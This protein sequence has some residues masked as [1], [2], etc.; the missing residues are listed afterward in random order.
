MLACAGIVGVIVYAIYYVVRM[1]Y[2]AKGNTLLGYFALFSLFMFGVYG[3][4]ENNEFNIVLM[5]MTTV[6]TVVGLMNKKGSDDKPLP[7]Y[8]KT[9]K[10]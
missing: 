8:I 3:M 9:P 4:M 1:K 2:L 7:L 10:F 6:I 5:F